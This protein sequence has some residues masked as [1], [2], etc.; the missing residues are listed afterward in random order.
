MM[1]V[2]VELKWGDKTHT[3]SPDKVLGAIAV[4]E[5]HITMA[6]LAEE[7]QARR[8][9]V[10]RLARTFG[11]LLRYAGSRVT[12][13]EVYVELFR[14]EPEEVKQRMFESI[15]TL[16]ALMIPPSTVAGTLRGNGQ[17]VSGTA[18]RSSRR[19]TR[20]SSGAAG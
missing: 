6:E 17:G 18:A 12:D 2:P 16:M 1:F 11:A 5:E 4:I 7:A 14:G 19:S 3:I 9:K 13:D 15:N 20:R 10:A 8:L